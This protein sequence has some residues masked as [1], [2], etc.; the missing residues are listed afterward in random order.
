MLGIGSALYATACGLRR[1]WGL[2]MMRT[3][4]MERVVVV[5][6]RGVIGLGVIVAKEAILELI[7]STMLNSET[8]ESL[9]SST[10]SRSSD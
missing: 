4:L 3:L 9:L 10:L 8:I 2:N 7:W 6:A 1:Q 5:R